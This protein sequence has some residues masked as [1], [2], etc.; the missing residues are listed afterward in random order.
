MIEGLRIECQLNFLY[1]FILL[2]L[3]IFIHTYFVI[4]ET[5][6]LKLRHFTPLPHYMFRPQRAIIRCLVL[7]KLFLC[8]KHVKYLFIYTMCKYDV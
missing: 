8:I 2:H 4:N 5:F 3:Y 7:L 6:G 1:L